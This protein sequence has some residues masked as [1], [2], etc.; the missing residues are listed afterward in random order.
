M[1]TRFRRTLLLAAVA[2]GAVGGNLAAAAAP[3]TASTVQLDGPTLTYD[4]A[5]GDAT[6]LTLSSAGDTLTVTGTGATVTAGPSCTSA[7]STKPTCPAAGVAAMA[8]STGD[9]NDTAS[10]S[11]TWIPTTFDD[12]PGPDAMTGGGAVDT[13]VAGTGSDTYRGGGGQDIVDYSS[14]TA[15]LTVS[16]DGL[17]NDGETGEEDN[18]GSDVDVVIGGSAGDPII[19]S[20]GN[21]VVS[22]GVGDD[23]LDGGDAND[24]LDGGA[25]NDS[26]QGGAGNDT[27]TGGSGNDT[28]D[29]GDGADTLAGGDGEDLADYSSRTSA[30]TISLNNSGDD[31]ASGERDNVKTDV[32]DVTVGSGADKITGDSADNILI[33]GAGNDTLD[34]GA[35]NDVMRGGAGDDKPLHGL[36]TH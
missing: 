8:V 23:R 25:G 22:G 5:P 36:G 6:R 1:N 14:R 4:A 21:N 30:L 27:L 33:G 20:G 28:L 13:F 26:L 35:G 24:S 31:G 29:G 15:P 9:M 34:G 17:A 10:V 12:G 19:G 11:G 18:V 2:L 16:L 7:S 32:E 3:A